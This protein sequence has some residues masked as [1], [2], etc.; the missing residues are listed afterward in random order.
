MVKSSEKL[1]SII[2]PVFCQEGTIRDDLERIRE[3][4]KE[5]FLNWEMVVVIDGMV[6]GSYERAKKIESKRIKVV[7]YRKNKGKGYAIRYGIARTKGDPVIFIDSG[8]EIDPIGIRMLW[9][10]MEWYKAD[11]VIGSKRHRESVVNY[12]W[13]RKVIS[14]LYQMFVRIFTG[15][16]VTDSQCGLKAYRR[17]VLI[18]IMPR[19]LVKAYAF[20]LEM[21][22]VARHVGFKKIYEAPVRLDYNF[23]DLVHA[24]TIEALKRALID[25]L[26]IIYRLRIVRYYDDGS[27]RKWRYDK[28]LNFRV[29]IG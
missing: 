22:V 29:N 5:S 16:N 3:V 19:L 28:E 8:M 1:V 15:V 14:F 13:E 25:T 7:G 12:P 18:K 26:A 24:H 9:E 6:D 27:K 20:D 10:K 11:I 17:Q 23:K 21:L 4:L 2:V